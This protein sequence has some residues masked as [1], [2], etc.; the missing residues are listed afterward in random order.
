MPYLF[1]DAPRFT[2]RNLLIGTAWVAVWG[3]LLVYF[4]VVYVEA[5]LLIIPHLAMLIVMPLVAIGSVLGEVKG[6]VVY[7]LFTVFAIVSLVGFVVSVVALASQ[8]MN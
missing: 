5:K 7:G 4:K 8:W 6:G 2:I 3:T 1:M